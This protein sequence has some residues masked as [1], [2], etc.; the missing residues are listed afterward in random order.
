VTSDDDNPWTTRG[1]TVAYDN[2]WIRVEHHDVLTPAGKPG[3]YG[4]VRF[5]NVAVG[6]IPLDGDGEASATWIVGQYRYPLGRYSWEIPEGGGPHDVPTLESARR[7]LLEE[8]GLEARRWDL[9]LEMD[10]SNSVSDERAE[11]WL[12][13][14]LVMRAP[15]PE[16]TERLAVRKV[17]FAELFRE[18][19]AGT[20]RDSLTVAGVLKLKLLLADGRV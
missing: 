10:L 1:V 3:I 16:E 14:D 9:I 6:V 5:K 4:C 13:R 7:E 11:I 15:H 12:A 8:V 2:P 17:P 18:V 20:H 19:M